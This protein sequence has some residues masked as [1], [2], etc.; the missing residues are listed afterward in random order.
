MGAAERLQITYLE[1][2]TNYS[3]RKGLQGRRR[4][5]DICGERVRCE[6]GLPLVLTTHVLGR[7]AGDPAPGKAFPV[8]PRPA[9]GGSVPL[10]CPG[11][12]CLGPEQARVPAGRQQAGPL[13]AGEGLFQPML[14]WWPMAKSATT[15]GV[16]KGHLVCP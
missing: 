1:W 3:H 16:G 8:A 7:T 12:A 4:K 6:P 11:G 15:Y 5:A 2:C 10:L 13:R 14:C 9:M